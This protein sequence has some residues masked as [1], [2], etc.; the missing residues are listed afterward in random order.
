M[1]VQSNSKEQKI[2]QL[3]PQEIT[4]YMGEI[5]YWLHFSIVIMLYEVMCLHIRLRSAHAAMITYD[6]TIPLLNSFVKDAVVL[7]RPSS[8]PN[9]CTLGCVVEVKNNKVFVELIFKVRILFSLSLLQIVKE[10]V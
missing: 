3:L 5:L 6:P 10:K 4:Q 1:R 8:N 2:V 9:W 7:V